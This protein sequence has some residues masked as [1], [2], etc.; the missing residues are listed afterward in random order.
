MLKRREF[1]LSSLAAAL[2]P[3]AVVAAMHADKALSW[4]DYLDAML[5]LAS[6]HADRGLPQTEM[7]AQGIQLLQR[8]DTADPDFHEAVQ[9]AY[10]TGNRFW[11]WQRLTKASGING[12]ILTIEQDEDVPLHDHPGATGMLRMLTG[13]AE[14]WQ[15]DRP[16]M[17][18]N[19]ASGTRAVI[20]RVTH[21]ILRPGDI[22]LLSPE[23]GNIHAL[24]ARSKSCSM[25]DYFIPPYQRSERTWYQPADDNWHDALQVSCRCISENNFYMS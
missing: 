9:S 15:F 21:R 17:T 23:H 7:A 3:D 2:L 12:G 13:E 6:A 10:E 18:V 4:T 14:L 20:E 25:L 1:M 22:A 5:K 24:R 11:L 16:E 19:V 8:L